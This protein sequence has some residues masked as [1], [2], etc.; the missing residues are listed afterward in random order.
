MIHY[1]S[2]RE[3]AKKLEVNLARWK[4][5][6]RSFLAPDPLGGLQS[7]F[8]RQYTFKD[9]V[10]VYVG[11]HLLSHLKLSVA[12]SQQ[13]VAD[14]TPWLKKSGFLEINGPGSDTCRI[15]CRIYFS[16]RTLPAG[17]RGSQFI[18]WV[19]QTIAREALAGATGVRMHEVYEETCIGCEP[20]GD[21]KFF[22]RPDVYLLN[23]SAVFS[24][25]VEKL[26][27]APV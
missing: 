2:N 19:R 24:R 23:L 27:S 20:G 21:A 11:G 5:W 8:S 4:R 10:K 12:E 3:C 9:L 15:A 14:I 18:Y 26:R 6:S 17:T 1:Y 25:M 16:R 7:G 13:V 22:E